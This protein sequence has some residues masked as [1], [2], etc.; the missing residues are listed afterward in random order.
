MEDHGDY[1]A[2][3]LLGQQAVFAQSL[4][5]VFNVDDGIVDQR[6]DS[7]GDAAKRHGVERVA[8][9]MKG[10]GCKYYRHRQGDDRNYCGAQVHQE[11]EQHNNHK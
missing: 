4:E 8:Q 3:L 9:E 5:H 7:D 6:T 2:T 1:V 10:D 11:E